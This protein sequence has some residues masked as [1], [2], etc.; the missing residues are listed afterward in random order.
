[1]RERYYITVFGGQSVP[2]R[3]QQTH[4]W[5]T[6]ARTVI[7]PDGE[8][9]VEVQTISWMPATMRIRPL[10]LRPE[11]GVNLTLSQ[12]YAWMASVGGRVSVWGPYELT[13]DQYMRYM[14]RKEELDL[15]EIAYRAL[16]GLRKDAPVSN[17][18]QSFSRASRRL[19]REYEEPT[20]APGINGTSVLVKR[21]IDSGVF[22]PTQHLWLLPLI[23]A[24]QY[25]TTHREPGERVPKRRFR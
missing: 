19:A 15:G 6:F 2:Y 11:P 21:Y 22:P 8:R 3:T 5:A 12:T 4:T 24:D 20:P 7:G 13:A 23:G 18:G 1:V 9:P 16:G 17:C 25:P 10:A 14:E